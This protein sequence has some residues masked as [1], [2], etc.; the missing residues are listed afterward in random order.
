MKRALL[1][2][3]HKQHLDQGTAIVEGVNEALAEDGAAIEQ[4]AKLGGVPA[5]ELGN[6]VDAAVQDAAEEIEQAV[7]DFQPAASRSRK[8]EV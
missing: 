3:I 8:K 7:I 2:K 5:D 6:A 4:A 1:R